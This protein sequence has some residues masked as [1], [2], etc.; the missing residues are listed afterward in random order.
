[1]RTVELSRMV[2]AT[3]V[4]VAGLLAAADRAFA[5][6]QPPQHPVAAHRARVHHA[7]QTHR[8]NVGGAIQTHR[9]NVGG[10]IQTHRQNVGD[11][12]RTR[13][14]NVVDRRTAARATLAACD[15]ATIASDGTVALPPMTIVAPPPSTPVTVVQPTTPAPTPAPTTPAT[16]TDPPPGAAA[17]QA[18]DEALSS[19]ELPDAFA[20]STSYDVVRIEDRGTTVVL[21]VGGNQTK[22]RLVGVAPVT[23]GQNVNL[24][25]RPGGRRLPSTE[26]FVENLLKGE[27]VYVVYDTNVNEEDVD[28]KCVA[29]VFRAPDG[30]LVNLEVIRAGFAVVDTRYAFD[31]KDVFM[32]YQEAAKKADKGIYGII[33]RIRAARDGK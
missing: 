21:K 7:V 30:L 16:T 1:M 32:R 2:I 24:P 4:A 28:R 22:V 3:G 15:P 27:K 33:K 11:A 6:A 29:Y 31:Q 23:L 5:Q 20:G 9:Q 26:G 18:D 13:A 19:D 17:E 12:R 25:D 14:G 10:A 8:Q